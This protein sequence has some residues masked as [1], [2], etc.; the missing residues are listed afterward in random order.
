MEQIFR[1]IRTVPETKKFYSVKIFENN[2]IE[3]VTQIAQQK[4]SISKLKNRII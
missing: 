1:L 4:K 3:Y 2:I